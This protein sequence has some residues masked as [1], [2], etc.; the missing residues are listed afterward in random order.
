LFNLQGTRSNRGTVDTILRLPQF[1]NTFFQVFL[2]FFQ[3]IIK[4]KIEP[5]GIMFYY[6]M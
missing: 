1:V 2:D 4:T 3:G 5:D 6:Y